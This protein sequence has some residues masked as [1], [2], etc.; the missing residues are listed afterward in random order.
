[1]RTRWAPQ[2]GFWMSRCRIACGLMV[3][4]LT[5]QG[6]TVS[7]LPRHCLV[8]IFGC[9]SGCCLASYRQSVSSRLGAL[10][11]RYKRGCAVVVMVVWWCGGGGGGGG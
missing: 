6:L 8:A 7:A 9:V 5:G 3:P 1:M 10:D 2:N 4:M 11:H